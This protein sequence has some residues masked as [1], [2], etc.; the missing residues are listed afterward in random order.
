[1]SR[2]AGVQ[3]SFLSPAVYNKIGLAIVVP[4]TSR[5]KGYP[6]EVAI[7]DGMA[8]TGVVLADAVKTVD[9][10]A[11]RARFVEALPVGT[12]KKVQEHLALRLSLPR[13]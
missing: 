2:R 12:L 7:P 9:W 3:R 13:G 5:A 8:T 1:M 6:F 11:R 10:R 4:I